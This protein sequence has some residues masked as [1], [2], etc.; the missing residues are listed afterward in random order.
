MN[1]VLCKLLN[2]LT[3]EITNNLAES[4]KN[5]LAVGF[6]C[7]NVFLY[8]SLFPYKSIFYYR[9]L[10]NCL[11]FIIDIEYQWYNPILYVQF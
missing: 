1:D 11:Y 7:V 5:N 4:I 8:I 3:F 10:S 9:S 2:S 6:F